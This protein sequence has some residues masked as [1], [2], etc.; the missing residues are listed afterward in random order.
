MILKI[1]TDL[2]AEVKRKT[3]TKMM[4]VQKVMKKKK[5][6]LNLYLDLDVKI[7]RNDFQVTLVA[8][9]TLKTRIQKIWRI[10]LKN[11]MASLKGEEDNII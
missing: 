5:M 2:V 7:Q 8:S 6:T 1:F 4:K 9:L 3:A 10:C 11:A